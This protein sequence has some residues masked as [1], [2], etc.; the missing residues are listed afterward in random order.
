MLGGVKLD[1]RIDDLFKRVESLEKSVKGLFKSRGVK[2]LEKNGI[3]YAIDGAEKLLIDSSTD[4]N[5][6][7]QS[8]VYYLSESKESDKILLTEEEAG[9]VEKW[10]RA[11]MDTD[12][13]DQ[14]AEDDVLGEDSQLYNKFCD[15]LKMPEHK[16][17]YKKGAKTEPYKPLI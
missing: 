2:I 13:W 5:H 10:A 1:P 8:A 12:H 15:F 9:L 4:P 17:D 11:F 6:V 14:D 16:I 3:Y 7:I